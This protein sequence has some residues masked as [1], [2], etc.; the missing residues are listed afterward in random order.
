MNKHF[1]KITQISC[2]VLVSFLIA[3]NKSES[4]TPPINKD[5]KQAASLN[6]TCVNREN[7]PE[8]MDRAIVIMVSL[9]GF[10][11]DYLQKINP[12]NLKRIL[13]EGIYS[14]GMIPSFPSHT[15]PNHYTLVTG[16]RP[17]NHGIISNIFWDESRNEKY[18]A[19]DDS[20]SDGSWYQGDPIW[21]VV[22]KNGML[23]HVNQWVGAE[24]HVNNQDPTCYAPYSS[25]VTT[26]QRMDIVI[27]WLKLPSEKRPH[28]ISTYVALIDSAGHYYGPDSKEVKDTVLNVDR[29]I[30]RLWNFI[31][32]SDL[33]INLVI[34]SDHG[35]QENFQDKIIFLG[36]KA[37]LSGFKWGDKGANV[38][39]YHDDESRIAEVYQSLKA[40]ENN[41]KVYLRKDIPAEYHLTNPNRVGDVLVVSEAGHYLTDRNFNPDR[42]YRIGGGSHG[43]PV[44]NKSMHALFIA[45]GSHITKRRNAI[46]EFS[47]IDVYPFVMELLGVTTAI[48]FDG[49]A[50][51]LQSYILND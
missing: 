13:K 4:P 38:M 28:Y 14:K 33:P 7:K 17:A 2:A 11:A 32:A 35:M 31:Q 1:Q 21:N 5:I 51:T 12:P 39:L 46:P 20:S 22:E 49:T 6:L 34:V 26:A 37:D 40:K 45:A 10:R 43:W 16:R 25:R 3:C 44:D 9:D 48:P 19:F 30:G 36:D 27:D 47:N 42:P 18:D 50:K 23:A 29:E 24:V 8:M 15:Y 41:Y